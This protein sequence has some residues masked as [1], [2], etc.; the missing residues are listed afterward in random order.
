MRITFISDTHNQHT[1]LHLPPADMLVHAGD[2][3]G[4]GT[5]PEVNTFMKW[6]D[7]QPHK[8]KVIIAGNHDFLA[9]RDKTLFQSILPAGVTYLDDSGATIEGINI[10]GS[11]IQPWFHDWA[12]NR[13]RGPD[14]ARHWELIPDDTDLLITHGPPL[15]I[16]DTL[17]NGTP[18][19]CEDL[20]HH[21]HRVKPRIHVFGHIHEAAGQAHIDGTHYINA[22]VLDLRYRYRNA[23]VTIKWK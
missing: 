6:L 15:G 4:R 13:Q 19:G 2:F 8:H 7:A 3:S 11:P 18:I 20:L 14:I 16:L 5:L 10:W 9:E 23:P 1:A 17:A 12:F 21:V 22:S